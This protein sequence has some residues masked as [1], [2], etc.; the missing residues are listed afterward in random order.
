M[1]TIIKYVLLDLMKNKIV[2]F[3]TVFLLAISI[4]VFSLDENATKGMMSLLNID[5]IFIPLVSIIFS[6]I[7]IYNSSEFI[8]LLVAQPLQRK[9]IWLSIYTGLALSLSLAFFIGIGIP[10]LIFDGTSTGFILLLSGLFQTIIFTG[11]ALAASVYARDKAKGI[12]ISMLLW[13]FFTVIYDAIVL[14]LLFQLSDYPMENPMIM[15]SMINPVDLSRILVLLKLDVSALMGYTGAVF[16]DFFGSMTGIMISAFVLLIW[17]I[18]PLWLS[19]KK[20]Q[21]KDL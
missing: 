21:R 5:L 17:S 18:L 14:L 6:T 12:G 9:S 11:I 1:R 19:L 10:V 20:F 7:Y 4:G 2:L 3:Y 8:E 16:N 13:F 15:L